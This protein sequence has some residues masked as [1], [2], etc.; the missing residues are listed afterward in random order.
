MRWAYNIATC[1]C[2]LK[3]LVAS[4]SWSPENLSIPVQGQFY[5]LLAVVQQ[6]VV[7][8]LCIFELEILRVKFQNRSPICLK[9]SQNVQYTYASGVTHNLATSWYRG[10]GSRNVICYRNPFDVNMVV[11]SCTM[12][13]QPWNM[14]S[15]TADK[16]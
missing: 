16:G 3:I 5:L 4:T 10:V 6:T 15:R 11:F 13:P 8:F 1:M 12:G 14:Q 2:R 9:L 7:F